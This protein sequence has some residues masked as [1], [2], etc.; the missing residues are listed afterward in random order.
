MIVTIHQ[1]DFMP[2]YGL[3][4]KIAAA[5][6]W[7]VLDHTENNP[8]DAAFWGRRVKTLNNGEGQ[9]FSVTL[10]KAPKGVV[11]I[12]VF[13][14]TLN[15]TNK[16]LLDKSVRTIQQAYAKTPFFKDYFY[17]VEHYFNHESANLM[18]R[19]M[20]FMTD[21]MALLNI[22]TKVVYS[23][24][25]AVAT[26]STELLVDL[27]KKVDATTYLCGNG[28]DGYQQDELFAQAKIELMYNE[29]RHPSYPQIRSDEFVG[30]L[31]ILDGLFHLG[32]EAVS[33]WVKP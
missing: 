29:V 20:Q 32:A 12:P 27:L 15:L 14:M 10:N 3:F 6:T 2:W 26:A 30:G 22:D 19:N 1:P 17:L 8:R 4:Q 28:A 23:S 7:I 13:D 11:G 18:V 31:S 16:K 25:L 5:D 9:W 21:V 24:S 33:Q